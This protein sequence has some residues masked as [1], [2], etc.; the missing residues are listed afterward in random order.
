M[1]ENKWR[2]DSQAVSQVDTITIAGAPAAGDTV[3]VARNRKE[4]TY[5]VIGGDTA[6]TIAQALQ[7]LLNAS[8]LIEFREATWSYP[9]SGG[10][11]TVTAATSG[12][13]YT[14]TVSKTGG[15][16]IALANI[17]PS[18]G[19]NHYDDPDNWSLGTVPAGVDTTVIDGGSALLYGSGTIAG[20]TI[21]IRNGF[22]A[23]IGLPERNLAGY[24]E[25]RTRYVTLNSAT[26]TIG[27]GDGSGA[28][29]LF[30]KA[31][32]GSTWTVKATGQ[33]ETD[34]IPALD[35]STTGNPAKVSV[36]GGDVG[37]C[38]G[39]PG[40]SP[41][42]PSGALS[43]GGRLTAGRS[44]T[45]TAFDM[46]AGTFDMWG[47][48]T[49]IVMGDGFYNQKSGVL[50]SINSTGGYVRMEQEGTVAVA[51]FFG[52]GGGQNSPICDCEVNGLARVFTNGQFTGG[53][54]LYDT[55][56]SVTFTNPVT[57]DQLSLAS[58]RLG[59]RFLI[60]RM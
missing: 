16:T 17:T 8:T 1:A 32:A 38:V 13:P 19:P 58:S 46:D 18:K 36:S 25:D 35:I 37:V 23:G 40:S 41:V 21:E 30:V 12:Q 43:S 48:M 9:G 60:Q 33:R 2:G 56:T 28:G 47:T 34:A 7:T 22:S 15:V 39:D 10:V 3:T 24:V 53:A 51:N 57:F 45:F 29:R 49:A 44:V 20:L 26:V 52:Q 11:I 4:V 27:E 31:V 59:K 6:A 14:F 42:V 5:T 54:A 50:T 55:N